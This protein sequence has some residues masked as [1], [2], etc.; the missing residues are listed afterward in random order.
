MA[1]LNN[2]TN[3]PFRRRGWSDKFRDAIRGTYLG[4]QGQTSFY[5][6][7][8]V[9]LAVICASWLLRIPLLEW[10][11]VI[12][13]ITF[14]LVAEMFNSS[15]EALAKAIDTKPNSEIGKALDISSAAVLLA[16]MAAATLG[17]AL[18]IHRLN[19]VFCGDS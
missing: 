6:H 9:A 15:L 18:F 14:V 5:V 19:M 4:V 17:S 16:S 12:L 7:F 1:E 10:G 3:R 11:V 8:S 13:C 2:G